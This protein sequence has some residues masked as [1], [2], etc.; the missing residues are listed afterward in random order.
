MTAD[1]NLHFITGCISK[2]NSVTADGNLQFITGCIDKNNLVMVY[3]VNKNI[4]LLDLFFIY[5]TII[6]IVKHKLKI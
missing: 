1:G 6:K 5:C 3:K 4:L 2:N